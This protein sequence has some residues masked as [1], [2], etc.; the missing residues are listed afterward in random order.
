MKISIIMDQYN[1]PHAGTESQVLKLVR[2]LQDKGWDVRFAVLRGTDY[3]RSGHFPVPVEELG[4]GSL[5]H[6][7]S[8]W[9]VYRYARRL[10]AEGVGL[11][12]VFFNDAS[13]L[14]P[15]M[16]RLAGIQTIISRR[17]M[18]FW[19]SPLYLKALRLTGRWVSAAICNSQAVARVT[20]ESENL[21]EDKLHVIYNG[22]PGI[23]ETPE[24]SYAVAGSVRVGIVAN[25]R[26]IKRIDDLIR[27]A[28][29]VVADGG[30]I[31][32]SV[33]GGGDSAPYEALARQLGM[34]ER[35]EFHG[36]QPEPEH[37]IREFDIA[38]LCS[39]SEGFSNAIIEYMRCG[40]PVICTRTGGNPEIVSD[41]DNGFLIEVGDVEALARHI[42]TLTERP[43]LRRKMG[44]A[45]KLKVT[46]QY[47]VDTML[48]HHVAL[49]EQ[50]MG[51]EAWAC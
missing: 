43:E 49:Y 18:G 12:H 16:M 48:A 46:R 7:A 39:E 1:H 41:G 2:G 4:V 24:P 27:A 34:A 21:P 28:A 19:Y 15:P 17:D 33:V 36:S 38:V 6:P 51:R 32:I 45:G 11:V 8:W 42:A 23:G 37:F 9:S 14:C 13:V 40:K 50:L 22:Y 35:V 44:E 10:Q 3:S 30:D 47:S 25:L 20:G 29:K 31:R 26:P 5:S